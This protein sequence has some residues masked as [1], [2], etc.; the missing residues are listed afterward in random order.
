M[1]FVLLVDIDAWGAFWLLFFF[2][3]AGLKALT[4]ELWFW[5]IALMLAYLTFELIRAHVR[6]RRRR[7]KEH[8]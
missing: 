6:Q 5:V 1:S 8:D 7:M 3:V 2:G 4:H